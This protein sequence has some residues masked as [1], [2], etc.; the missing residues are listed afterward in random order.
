MKEVIPNSISKNIFH[1]LYSTAAASFLNALVLIYLASYLEAFH[2]GMFS[3]VLASAMVMGYFT[4][5]GL[6]EIAIR[7]GSKKEAD[8]VAILSSYLKV[9]ALLL[10]L[11]LAGG[12]CYISFFYN[13]NPELTKLAY[14]LSIPMVFGLAF[15]G[16]GTMFFQLVQKMQYIGF[17]KMFTALLLI[18]TLGMSMF[19][20]LTPVIVCFLYGFS[21]FIAGIFALVLVARHIPF[22]LDVPFLP[23]FLKN[24]TSFMLSGLLFIITPQLGPI[25]LEKTL[26]LKEVG[27]FAV[28]YRIPQA[29]QQLPLIVAGAYR[30]VMFT[31]FHR[32]RMDQHVDLNV[33][34]IKLMAICGMVI[35]IPLFYLS[36]EIILFL[37]G[38]SWLLSSQ[39]LK[40]LS[41]LLLIQAVGVGLADGLTTRGL[42]KFRT[43][44]QLFSVLTGIAVYILFSNTYGITGGALAGLSVELIALI[45]YYL[46]LPQKR[47]IALKSFVPYFLYFGLFLY[48]C[49]LIMTTY[50][51]LAAVIHL[52]SVGFLVILDKEMKRK[53]VGLYDIVR[54]K[55]KMRERVEDA[56]HK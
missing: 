13:D 28:A 39:A 43:G 3:V 18:C 52:M 40:I 2:Y 47:T 5:A 26:T 16:I 11:T 30:P 4:D 41:L 44:I 9:R 53:L 55:L 34:L 51:Y 20:S 49:S 8:R 50:P 45:G 56:I 36:D 17:I 21:Y 37:F 6:T 25:I 48:L 10:L 32:K 38:E 29:L 54:S 1:L 35:T 46:F 19:L 12:A 33:T 24:F 27:L 23:G 14:C 42:Q 31:H 7:E 15:Q 22:R